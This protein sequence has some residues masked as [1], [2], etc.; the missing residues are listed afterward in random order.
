[1]HNLGALLSAIAFVLPRILERKVAEEYRLR[2][3][4]L[5]VACTLRD[6]T[7]SMRVAATSGPRARAAS[8]LPRFSVRSVLVEEFFRVSGNMHGPKIFFEFES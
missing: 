7:L 5:D 4:E 6:G 1:M 8:G 3:G 2:W